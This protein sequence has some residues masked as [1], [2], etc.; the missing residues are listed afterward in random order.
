[1]RIGKGLNG[2]FQAHQFKIDRRRPGTFVVPATLFST[3]GNPSNQT[4]AYYCGAKLHRFL[5]QFHFQVRPAIFL[6]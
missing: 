3:S 1:M 2:V 4:K 5:Q 6:L